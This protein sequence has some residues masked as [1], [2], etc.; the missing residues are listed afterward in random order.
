M[1][2]VP[3]KLS[4]Q[5]AAGKP[6]G[7]LQACAIIFGAAFAGGFSSAAYPENLDTIGFILGCAVAV[8]LL[9]TLIVVWIRG[10]AAAVIGAVAAAVVCAVL[11][12]F[13]A[14][15]LYSLSGRKAVVEATEEVQRASHAEA[16]AA[17][18]DLA[19]GGSGEVDSTASKQAL[20]K[21]RAVAKKSS[22]KNSRIL[23]AL[24]P[25]NEETKAVTTQLN[26]LGE[27]TLNNDFLS[28][29]NIANQAELDARMAK[30]AANREAALRYRT[31]NETLEERST[32]ALAK[33]GLPKAEV[34]H[35]VRVYLRGK[36]L[37][38]VRPVAQN[39][40]TIGELLSARFE[41]LKSEWG[42][43]KVSGGQP[44]FQR[45][46]AVAQWNDLSTRV[47]KLLEEQS[48][49]NRRFLAARNAALSLEPEYTIVEDN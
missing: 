37:E 22:P 21:L 4:G 42:R 18:R 36:N 7:R 6:L 33:L 10:A 12:S 45:A 24:I 35:A 20:E 15:I 49:Y 31:V 30:L 2:E 5:P 38:I 39:N 25:I 23:E 44:V 3:P 1:N 9:S 43:W 17:Q 34:D 48:D 11:A 8:T 28:P 32:V 14:E 41:V 13:Q 16:Q 26:A 46:K 19:A 47:A 27:Q 29:Q 40:V